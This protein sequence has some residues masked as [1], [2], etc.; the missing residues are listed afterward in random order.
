MHSCASLASANTG[1]C[2]T[3]YVV[4]SQPHTQTLMVATY[5]YVGFEIVKLVLHKT[6]KERNYMQL[7][8]EVKVEEK[9]AVVF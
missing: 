2:I 6:P 8:I 3:I 9:V 4:C 5:Y 1:V 7:Y